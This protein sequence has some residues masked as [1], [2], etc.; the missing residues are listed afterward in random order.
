MI[1]DL[2][3]ALRQLRKSPGFT[4]VVVITLALGVGANAAIFTRVRG[5]CTKP[6]VNRDEDRLIYI[7]QSAP[8]MDQENS[9]WSMPE[10][11]DLKER[12]KTLSEF[13]DFSTIAFTLIGLGDPREVNGGVVNG[14]FFE[15]RGLRPGLGRLVGP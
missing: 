12:V 10:I 1:A 13:G 7:R 8:G 15:G 4:F 11:G 3:F 5:V 6:L 2:R 9:T 14:S